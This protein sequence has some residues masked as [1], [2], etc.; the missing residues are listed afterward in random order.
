MGVI[1]ID[2]GQSATS[3]ACPCCGNA[4][5]TVWG[6]VSVDDTARAV[7]FCRWTQ[8]H[9]E[10][11]M[12]AAISIGEWGEAPQ[13]AQRQLVGLEC[14]VQENRPTFMI[15]N[16][17]DSPWSHRRELGTNLSR[18]TA[19]S[20]P[21]CQESFDIIDRIITDDQRVKNFLAGTDGLR[22]D[23]YGLKGSD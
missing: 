14:R 19:L 9:T 22:R 8:G 6:Y 7:Y 1:R 17:A 15:I 4:T 18:E 21:L 11:G 20:G 23:V 10:Q 13:P 16:A 5:K 3:G 2:P 12:S